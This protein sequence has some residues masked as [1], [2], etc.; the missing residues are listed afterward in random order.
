MRERL[1]D[2]E[3]SSIF[4][5][6]KAFVMHISTFNYQRTQTAPPLISAWSYSVHSH[7]CIQS[8]PHPANRFYNVYRAQLGNF[9]R[10]CFEALHSKVAFYC[11]T[12]QES[13]NPSTLEQPK[14]FSQHGF[15]RALLRKF[16]HIQQ[17]RPCTL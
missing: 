17:H 8:P 1:S 15:N 4:T 6:P 3:I 2:A 11:C 10:I 12:V 7:H 9:Q 16:S 5:H 14:G 13:K